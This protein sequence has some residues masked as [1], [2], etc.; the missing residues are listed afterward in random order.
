MSD[1]PAF[2]YRVSSNCIF[3]GRVDG[4]PWPNLGVDQTCVCSQCIST[5]CVHRVAMMWVTVPC[6]WCQHHFCV[7]AVQQQHGWPACPSPHPPGGTKTRLTHA[8]VSIL[9]I[10]SLTERYN[11]V[12]ACTVVEIITITCRPLKTGF[13][14]FLWTNIFAIE[15]DTT[16]IILAFHSE[17]NDYSS[18]ANIL[19]WWKL[20]KIG[21]N[22]FI[23]DLPFYQKFP[24][25]TIIYYSQNTKQ[26]ISVD[27][28]SWAEQNGTNNFVVACTVVEMFMCNC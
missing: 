3:S 20:P 18:N 4:E 17:S 25:F 2:V 14:W 23:I 9:T 6:V 11:F 5:L 8:H 19:Y 24:I 26:F 28:T 7:S 1:P 16:K 10:L 22:P 12:I 21:E 27:S 13:L 15:H